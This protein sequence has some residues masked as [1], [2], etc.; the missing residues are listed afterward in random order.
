MQRKVRLLVKEPGE[1]QEKE[2][3]EESPMAVDEGEGGGEGEEVSAIVTSLFLTFERILR[4]V[5]GLPLRENG[6]DR[7]QHRV[8]L[9]SAVPG[10]HSALSPSNKVQ[11]GA[12]MIPLRRVP[13]KPHQIQLR[14]VTSLSIDSKLTENGSA[15]GANMRVRPASL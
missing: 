2:E 6:R 15:I 7:L 9:K 11:A 8:E 1:K 4:A 3:G 10:R 12:V 5:G 13:T 14:C